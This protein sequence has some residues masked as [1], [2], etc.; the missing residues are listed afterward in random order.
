MPQGGDSDKLSLQDSFHANGFPPQ[1]PLPQPLA[2]GCVLLIQRNGSKTVKGARTGVITLA[3][4]SAS[5]HHSLPRFMRYLSDRAAVSL[6]VGQFF[7]S[8]LV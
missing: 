4:P 5:Q 7:F 6:P 1:L 2:V 8:P 3:Y